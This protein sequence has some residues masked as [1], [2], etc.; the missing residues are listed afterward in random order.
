MKPALFSK[1]LNERP[2]DEAIDI[3]ADLGYD[4][5][6]IQASDPHLPV[7]TSRERAAEIKTSLD[8]A[9]IA[10]PCLATYTGY[11]DE[12][13]ES[14]AEAELDEL[15]KYCAL[16][17]MLDCE[18]VRHKPGGPPVRHAADDDFERAAGYLQRAA[19]IAATYD[20]TIGIEIHTDRLVETADSTL[21]FL[22]LVD[23]ENVGVIHDAGN[24]YIVDTDFGEESVRKLG[25]HLVHVH[26]KDIGR[27]ADDSDPATFTKETK[28]GTQHFQ[29]RRL[30]EGDTDH[31][32][33]FTALVEAGYDGYLTDECAVPTPNE[34]D[35]VDLARHE[36]E[37]IQRLTEQARA[38]A[39]QSADD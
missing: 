14:E 7:T 39:A 10:V 5:I 20:R 2:L 34:G 15:E 4:G 8:E 22:D 35:D 18:L 33:A 19:D 17:E 38:A 12:R 37:A 26:V 13:T 9:G 24:M 21:K 28:H 11:Y 29:H 27:V 3:T 32:P 23:R 31:L 36:L 6:E 25:D 1:I 16:A 30:G